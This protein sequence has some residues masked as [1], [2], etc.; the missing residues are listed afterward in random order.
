MYIFYLFEAVYIAHDISLE[1]KGL[2]CMSTMVAQSIWW[3]SP[4]KIWAQDVQIYLFGVQAERAKG[5]L[6]L[7]PGYL[8]AHLHDLRVQVHVYD[9]TY[10]QQKFWWR[11]DAPCNN[12]APCL[13]RLLG[14]K[15][16]FHLYSL[17]PQSPQF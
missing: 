4:F 2:E 13:A 6:H 10:V 1:K 5:V 16:L 15:E 12:V 11:N 14:R 3:P 7:C 9:S 17:S 8:D